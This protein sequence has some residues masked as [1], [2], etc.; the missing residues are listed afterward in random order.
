MFQTDIPI[1]PPMEEV[2][3]KLSH[4]AINL[5][6]AASDYGALKV[7][8]GVFIVIALIMVVL[9]FYQVIYQNK[10][11]TRI[12]RSTQDISKSLDMTDK[13]VGSVEASHIVRRSLNSFNMLIKYHIL[14]IRS[15]NNIVD[16]DMVRS[17]VNRTV[18]NNWNEIMNFLS[19]FLVDGK[20][21][22]CVLQSQSVSIIKE[23]MIEYIYKDKADFTINNMDVNLD[24]L[25]D[26]IKIE[27]L[28]KLD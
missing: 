28:K 13:I 7:V 2:V 14:R 20:P 5:A 8:F 3:D 9:F 21:L 6:E 10:L 19:I 15:E 22:S 1:K 16:H 11:I 4:S 25:F 23:A 17:K 12:Y 18:D 27:H 26:E 24:L